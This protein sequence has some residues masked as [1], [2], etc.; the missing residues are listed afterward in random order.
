MKLLTYRL[1][2]KKGKI[3]DKLKLINNLYYEVLEKDKFWH[4][5]LD[6]KGGTIRFQPKYE[7]RVKKFMSDNKEKFGFQK[8]KIYEPKK[9]EYY[10]VSYIGDD[11]LPLF[12]E[13][14]VLSAKYPTY[15]I[16]KPVLERLNHGLVNM[17]GLHNF[18]DEADIYLDLAFNRAK[19]GAETMKTPMFSLPKWVYELILMMYAKI[20]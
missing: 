14:S 11:L 17:S 5:F 19:L 13:M 6:G 9:S 8:R 1:N 20:H 12:H 7:V 2:Q 3:I 15:V 4:F 16:L 10:G 18:R